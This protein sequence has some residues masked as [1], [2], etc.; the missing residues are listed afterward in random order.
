MR[1]ESGQVYERKKHDWRALSVLKN[2]PFD[3]KDESGKDTEKNPEHYKPSNI[4][5]PVF[6]Y[7]GRNQRLG[8]FGTALKVDAQR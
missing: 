1:S 7:K 2:A 5:K 4:L 8:D 3:E 6:F